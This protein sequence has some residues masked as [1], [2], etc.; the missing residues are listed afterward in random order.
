MT[1]AK[2]FYVGAEYLTPSNIYEIKNPY[3]DEIVASI[4]MAQDDE[5]E[6]AVSHASESFNTISRICNE[7]RIR[8]LEG[9]RDGIIKRSEEIARRFDNFFL[10]C[11][12]T[13]F[14]MNKPFT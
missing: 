8:I 2:G 6:L 9:L 10:S 11:G 14:Q 4:H 13:P 12:L 5:R 1:M 7:E 3:N